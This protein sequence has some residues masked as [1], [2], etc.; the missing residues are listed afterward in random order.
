MFEVDIGNPDDLKKRAAGLNPD[1]TRLLIADAIT[2]QGEGIR[3][4]LAE[5]SAALRT[6][7][8]MA[9]A[10]NKLVESNA[11]TKKKPSKAKGA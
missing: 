3:A 5:L 11:P 6:F 1:V 9:E 10:L 7:A 2:Q 4:E 8:A